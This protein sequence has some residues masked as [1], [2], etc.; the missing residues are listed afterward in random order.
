MALTLRN[1]KG[2]ELTFEEM[3]SNFLHLNERIDSTGDSAYLKSV[4]DS[5][6]I[7]NF[8]DTDHIEGIVDSAYVNARLD[9]TS[10]LDSA[11]AIALID[12]AYV[13]ARLDTTS[14][15]DSAEAIALI[16]SAYINARLDT[17]QFLDSAEALA[18]IDSDY[19]LAI[20]PIGLDSAK[21]SSMIDSALSSVIDSD[22]IESKLGTVKFENYTAQ[23]TLTLA[24]EEGQ[25]IFVTDGSA[26]NPCLAIFSNGQWLVLSTLGTP[27]DSGGDSGGGGGF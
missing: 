18:L 3:D 24:G 22:Y 23:D 17:S 15:L 14:F 5:D 7:L 21:T 11:E 16:D 26:G 12:S 13:N 25:V 8:V 2:S 20:S 10:F 19:I 1:V 4:I 9:T 6:Y 27:V